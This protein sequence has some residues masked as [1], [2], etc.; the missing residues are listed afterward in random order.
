MAWG[1]WS[2][3][4]WSYHSMRS[5]DDRISRLS[6][7]DPSVATQFAVLAN[8]LFRKWLDGDTPTEFRVFETFRTA[9][10][11]R[12]L[13]D[14]KKTTNAEPFHSPH[15]HGL[16]VDFVPWVPG[17]GWSWANDNDWP[18]LRETAKAVGLRQ[19]YQW[20]KP[21]V[22]HRSWLPFKQLPSSELSRLYYQGLS[23]QQSRLGG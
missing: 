15:N 3:P 2:P 6:A 4:H 10:R 5:L 8:A 14:V 17:E 19:P 11:Q 23:D 9:E 20:D 16:A 1:G 22:E 21:H 18:T 12:Y 7:L 13:Y